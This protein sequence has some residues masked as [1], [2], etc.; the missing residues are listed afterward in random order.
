MNNR[1]QIALTL[2]PF[3]ALALSGLL[4]LAFVTFNSDLDFK[5]SEFAETTSEIMFNQNYVT[6]QARFIFKESVETCPA[7]SPKNLNTKFKDVADSKDLR[8]PGSGNF[9][10]KL[11]NGNFT[12]S[13][14]NS[15]RVLEIQDLFVQSEVGANKIVRNFNICFEFD[16]EGNFVK[17][18]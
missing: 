12:L 18:C 16:S 5:S 9:F 14:K 1:G 2:L 4:I 17:D 15:F 8:F 13:E 10:A 11:R 3:I 6:A 7:C